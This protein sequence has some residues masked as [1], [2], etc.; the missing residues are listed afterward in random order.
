[1]HHAEKTPAA[2]KRQ[3]KR[4]KPAEHLNLWNRRMEV[5]PGRS[6]ADAARRRYKRGQLFNVHRGDIS[7][8]GRLCVNPAASVRYLILGL[9]P[10]L[11]LLALCNIAGPR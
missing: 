10:A 1:M 8:G 3:R 6:D 11:A 7:C 9:S 2:A 4:R 5:N